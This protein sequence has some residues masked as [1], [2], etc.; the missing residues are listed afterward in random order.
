MLAAVLASAP[1][2]RSMHWV[3]GDIHGVG[4]CVVGRAPEASPE[5][6]GTSFPNTRSDL[7]VWTDATTAHAR[8]WI[9]CSTSVELEGSRSSRNGL[10][11]ALAP[12]NVLEVTTCM[13]GTVSARGSTQDFSVHAVVIDVSSGVAD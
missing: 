4:L 13:D 11:Q 9:E 3:H 2:M 12:W 6:V 8:A 1:S 10:L 7:G 5:D